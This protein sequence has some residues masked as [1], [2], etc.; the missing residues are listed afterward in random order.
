MRRRENFAGEYEE[1]EEAIRQEWKKPDYEFFDFEI[2]A[3][4]PC[5]QF[6]KF[7]WGK[8]DC[9]KDHKLSNDNDVGTWPCFQFV[10]TDGV[11]THE[12][13]G[14]EK[15]KF[16]KW[17]E[18]PYDDLIPYTDKPETLESLP[19]YDDEPGSDEEW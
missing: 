16:A 3:D 4:E 13:Q 6:K 9:D 19:S 10:S 2:A 7:A 1:G 17:T 5:A 18:K 15:E 8:I 12:I 11:I 14:Y